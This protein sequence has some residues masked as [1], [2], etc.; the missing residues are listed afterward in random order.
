MTL[1]FI[2]GVGALVTL[3]WLSLSTCRLIQ[4]IRTSEK[5]QFGNYVL[6]I[7]QQPTASFSWGKYIVISAAD[8]SQQSEEIL[9]HETMHLRNHH[10]LDLLFMQIF[11]LVYW[12]NPVVW[13]LK[14]EL[15]EV[16]EFEA[17]NGVINTGI[18][19]TK[20]QLLLVKKAV[21]TRLYSMANGFNHSKP[22]SYTHLT[23]PTI[24]SV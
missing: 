6:V 15:Q 19:A 12:F 22:V 14:R 13:L 20:Y 8:Y 16:H 7:P 9:L 17:D 4:L 11:L 21:G 2:Y 10:T 24:C 18:D 5:K 3:I 1:A 23:L